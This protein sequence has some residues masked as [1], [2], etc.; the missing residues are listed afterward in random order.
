[1]E[2][3]PEAPP[4][5]GGDRWG[6]RGPAAAIEAGAGGTGRGRGVPPAPVAWA[7][8]AGAACPHRRGS[9][10]G[11]RTARSGA[12]AVS[13]RG[14]TGRGGGGVT[15]RRWFVCL[16]PREVGRKAAERQKEGHEPGVE[17]FLLLYPQR[18]RGSACRGAA[19]MGDDFFH[20]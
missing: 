16:L 19:Q 9:L 7:A 1:M 3:Q 5:P 17:S 12:E 14:W 2:R 11:S 15:P 4:S 6:E 13:P 10:S 20:P 8:A 18:F